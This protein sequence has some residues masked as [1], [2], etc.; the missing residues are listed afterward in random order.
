M[1]AVVDIEAS[2]G[3][4]GSEKI[5]E[6]AIY[7]YDGNQIVDQFISLINPEKKIDPYVSRLTGITDKMVRNAPKFFE[8]AKRVIEITK[9]CILVGHG[10]EFDYRMLQNELKSLGFEYQSRTLDTLS[11]SRHA[12]PDQPTYSLG[13]LCKNIGIPLLE[14]HRASGDAKATVLLLELLLEKKSDETFI[15]QGEDLSKPSETNPKLKELIGETPSKK[16]VIYL[17]NSQ[18]ELLFIT[19]AYNL[20][21]VIRKLLTG[22]GKRRKEIQKIVHSIKVKLTKNYPIAFIKASAEIRQ[23]KPIFN[24]PLQERHHQFGLYL[25]GS[26]FTIEHLNDLSKLP[27]ISFSRKKEACHFVEKTLKLNLEKENPLEEIAA[28][29]NVCDYPLTDFYI[30]GEGRKDQEKSFLAL[31]KNQFIGYGYYQLHHQLKDPKKITNL[32][33]TIKETAEIK[34]EI[35]NYLL[36]YQPEINVQDE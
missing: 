19:A 18:K 5:I 22:N 36:V 14:R 26:T 31:V 30:L 16:G 12:L 2:G 32:L 17:Y 27:A 3:K 29:K 25:N 8:V 9:D 35:L 6:I 4:K 20:K 11:Y 10:V 23:Y 13:K 7:T 24:L 28:L 21:T 1:Y 33:V 15:S 34:S